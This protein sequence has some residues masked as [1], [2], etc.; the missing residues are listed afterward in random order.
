M[1]RYVSYYTRTVLYITDVSYYTW[2][3]GK[4]FV[5]QL[6]GSQFSKTVLH[7]GKMFFLL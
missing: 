1:Y 5:F 3:R 7:V 4:K 2:L 6:R